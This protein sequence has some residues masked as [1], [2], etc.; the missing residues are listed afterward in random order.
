[1]HHPVCIRLRNTP[2]PRTVLFQNAF[3][4]QHDPYTLVSRDGY[5][6]LYVPTEAADPFANGVVE[7]HDLP[8]VFDSHGRSFH[9]VEEVNMSPIGCAYCEVR[10]TTVQRYRMMDH[11]S[12][13]Q[14]A[15]CFYQM[16]V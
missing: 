12:R 5:P 2:L 7:E 3:W 4:L 14:V 15:W 9:L 6:V 1:M 16:A 13:Q 10:G 11:I 8:S